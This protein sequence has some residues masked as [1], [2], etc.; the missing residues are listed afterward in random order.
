MKKTQYQQDLEKEPFYN[1]KD[2]EFGEEVKFKIDK[3]SF[4]GPF[5][6]HGKKTV[7]TDKKT[8]YGDI[9]FAYN[10]WQCGK[11]KKEY[12]DFQQGRRYEKFLIEVKHK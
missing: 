3:D 2:G 5:E 7:L 10:V 1:I 6:C 4:K 12:L 9:E 11:C 8:S